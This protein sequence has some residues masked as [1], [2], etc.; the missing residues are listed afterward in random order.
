MNDN[1]DKDG[2]FRTTNLNRRYSLTIS[3]ITTQ[4]LAMVEER[5]GDE[6]KEDQDSKNTSRFTWLISVDDKMI[7]VQF[8]LKMKY[9]LT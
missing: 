9:I 1:Q 8:R 7:K 3:S 5:V 6:E 2:F 4:D